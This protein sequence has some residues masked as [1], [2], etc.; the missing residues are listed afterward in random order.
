MDDDLSALLRAHSSSKQRLVRD[1]AL[2]QI[3]RMI[4]DLEAIAAG[5]DPRRAAIARDVIRRILG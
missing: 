1:M 3:A 4:A 5:D 2:E